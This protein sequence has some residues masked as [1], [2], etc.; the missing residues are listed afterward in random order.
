MPIDEITIQ[1]EI[2]I[3]KLKYNYY[4]IKLITILFNKRRIAHIVG[5]GIISN[6]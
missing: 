6:V 4:Q 3:L 5:Y 2:Y 1:Y